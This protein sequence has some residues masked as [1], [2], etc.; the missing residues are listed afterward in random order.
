MLPT[1]LLCLLH[2]A[3]V[4]AQATRQQLPLN[5]PLSFS[6]SNSPPILII[7]NS[8]N[9]TVSIAICSED[10]GGSGQR[11]FLTNA[12]SDSPNVPGPGGNGV[13]EI[14]LNQGLGIFNGPFP[15]GGVLAV[16]GQGSFEVGASDSGPIHAILPTFPLLGDTTSSQALLFSAPFA[17]IEAAPEPTFPSYT[18]PQANLSIP[19]YTSTHNFS[20]ILA[21][22]T[23]QSGQRKLTD[24]SQTGCALNAQQSSNA[25]TAIN[26]TLWSRDADGW[27]NQWLIDGLT[28]ST[29][30]TAYVVQDNTKVSGPIYFATKSSAFPC[31][32]V[33]SL[34]YCPSV[35]YSV[36]IP[37]SLLPSGQ[38]AFD[39]DSLP[40]GISNPLLASLTNFTTMLSTFPCGRDMYSP[41]VTCQDCQIA[42]RRW[43]CAVS[44]VRCGESSP[45]RLDSFTATPV[46]STATGMGVRPTAAGQEVPS[47]LLPVSAPTASGSPNTRNQNIPA[48][49]TDYL[50]LLPCLETCTAVDR[51]CPPFLQF[52]CPLPKFNAGASYGVGYID[53]FGGDKGGGVTGVAQDRW[54]NVWCNGV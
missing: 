13:Y 28:P 22:T 45:Q 18:L 4:F 25:S 50:M 14:I 43:L 12:S 40:S 32:L 39:S 34:P 48:L 23:P 51:A 54:G 21:P 2:A 29:N 44:F 15:N 26:Q 33:H 42:Y 31:P 11:F 24:I 20:L 36:P 37:A 10:P 1:S 3:I 27:R 53:G 49:N 16:N 7:P 8:G 19:Q 30:Y 9:L 38:K 5:K 46:A 52:R 17:A 41:L 47:A 6:Q 35:A